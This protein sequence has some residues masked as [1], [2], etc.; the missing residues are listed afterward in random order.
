M[1]S[2][3][4]QC[5]L[6]QYLQDSC[7]SALTSVNELTDEEQELILWRSNSHSYC[8]SD[9]YVC[10]KHKDRYLRRFSLHK[11]ICCDPF[12]RHKRSVLSGLREVSLEKAKDFKIRGF[13]IVPGEKMC[14]TCTKL[15][16]EKQA[17]DDSS[18]DDINVSNVKV[19]TPEKAVLNTSL[20]SLGIS[21]AKLHSVARHSRSA[22]AKRKLE[23][24]TGALKTKISHVYQVELATEASNNPDSVLTIL[25]EKAKHHDELM[26]KIK[27]KIKHANNREKIQL[28]TLVPQTWSRQKVSSTFQV[29]EY[30]VRQ[31][32]ALVIEKGILSMPEQKRGKT[33]PH[34]TVQKVKSFYLDD[35]NS[36]I[37]PGKKDKVSTSKNT[38]EQKRL[39]LS[40]LAE[41]YSLYKKKYPEDKVGFSKFASLRPKQ[42]I[43]AGSSGTHTVCV[44][45]YHQ[46][47]KLLLNSISIKET[48]HDLIKIITCDINNRACMLRLCDK[49]SPPPQFFTS[50]TLRK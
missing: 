35:E 31:A 9:S 34:E 15:I 6:G 36:R 30:L 49:C 7:D 40:N 22:A 27:Q 28:L 26:D 5:F 20:T 1:E 43:L 4:R 38:Y 21:P 42:C 16:S 23:S 29:S 46:N 32:R 48:Y 45:T 19:Q 39:V 44:C 18:S 2:T 17:S 37:M 41:M 33:L 8:L 10:V 14:P 25:E 12:K 13:S 24:A 47:V 50:K 11:K 3:S